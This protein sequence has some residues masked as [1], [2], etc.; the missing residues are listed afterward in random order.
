MLYRMCV[1]GPQTALEPYLSTLACAVNPLETV[2]SVVSSVLLA[3][4]YDKFID[5]VYVCKNC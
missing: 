5:T 2:F 3:K 4:R 1:Q